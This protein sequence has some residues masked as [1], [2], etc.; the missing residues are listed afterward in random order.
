M[1]FASAGRMLSEGNKK[2]RRPR[3]PRNAVLLGRAAL[4]GYRPVIG[5]LCADGPPLGLSVSRIAA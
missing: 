2:S 1:L 5:A 3:S 4:P